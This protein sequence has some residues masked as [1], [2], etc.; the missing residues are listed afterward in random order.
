M[1]RLRRQ[2][3]PGGTHY[4][5]LHSNEGREIFLEPADYMA[6]T[7]LVERCARRCRAHIHAFC[8]T[9]HE[10]HFAVQVS[11]EPLGRLVQRI[12]GQHARYINR[13]LGQH[14]HVFQQCYWAALFERVV[15]LLEVVCH[16]YLMPMRA[17][18][19]TDLVEYPWSSHRT[20]LGFA[21]ISWV[22]TGT[23]FRMLESPGRY[24]RAAYREYVQEE[25]VR[26]AAQLAERT[27]PVDARAEDAAFLAR[28][29]PRRRPQCNPVLLSRIIDS[30][31]TKLAVPREDMLSPSRRRSLTLSRALVAWHAT[32]NDVATLTQVAHCFHRNPSTLCVGVERYRRVRRDLFEEP[33]TNLLVNG[34]ET[35][36][37]PELPTTTPPD[38]MSDTFGVR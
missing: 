25:V 17:G 14:G 20:Y 18:L 31:A 9:P 29:A 34:A 10:V 33:M 37:N 7:K 12:A 4:I 19:A 5:I 26:R 3:V 21:K 35:A 38:D 13:K 6:F 2:H 22:T 24:R 27:E 15:D 30:V 32:R 28:L 36:A 23:V 8:W 1:A 16:V 11:T